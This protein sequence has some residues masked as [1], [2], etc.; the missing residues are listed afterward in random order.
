TPGWGPAGSIGYL[1][2]V[3]RL[4][5]G[6]LSPP[7]ERRGS[8]IGYLFQASSQA[9]KSRRNT[10][11]TEKRRRVYGAEATV[12]RPPDPEELIHASCSTFAHGLYRAPRH[13]LRRREEARHSSSPKHYRQRRAQ[14]RAEPVEGRGLRAEGDRS[15]R[16]AGQGGSETS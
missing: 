6:N 14:G 16:R 3:R 2:P 1:S 13:R 8:F 10:V 11:A 5:V 7:K 12:A 15:R 9:R 4:M